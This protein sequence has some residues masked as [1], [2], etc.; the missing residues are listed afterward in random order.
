MDQIIIDQ[1]NR[2]ESRIQEYHGKMIAATSAQD[3]L[4]YSRTKKMYRMW[5]TKLLCELYK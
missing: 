2:I 1:L 4:R 3:R 5:R